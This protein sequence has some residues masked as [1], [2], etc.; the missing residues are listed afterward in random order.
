MNNPKIIFILSNIYEIANG[1][2]TKYITFIEYLLKNNYNVL[3]FTTFKNI[4]NYQNCQKDNNLKIIKTKGLIIPFYNTIKIPI[5]KE[6]KLK[7]HITEGNEIVI[8]NGEFIWLYETLY[9]IKKKYLNI[10]LYPNMH[11]DYIYY[12]N[13]VYSKF[14]FYNF[15]FDYTSLLSYLDNYLEKKIFNGIIVTGE[16]LK[17]K[18][19]LLTNS[20]FNANEINLDTFN[21]IKKDD[22]DG[23]FYNIIYCGRISK[24]KNIE[25][26]IDCCQ[27][28][29]DKYNYYLN[30]IGDGPYLDTLKTIIELEYSKI[31]SKIIFHGNKDQKSINSLYQSMENRIFLFTS[32]SETFG[33]T[34]MEAG[35]T[36]IPIFI[37]KCDITDILYINKKNAMIFDNKNDFF[38]LFVYFSEMDKFE[39]DLFISNSIDN[40]KKYDQ[41][42]IFKDWIQFL[43]E[44]KV[45]KKHSVV[46]FYDMFTF[47]GITKFINCSGSIIA[48]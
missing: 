34:P 33:K 44:G 22:Y 6:S 28:L 41:N 38:E 48:D 5:I 31:K 20:V 46:N 35:A 4:E 7:E 15:K 8:F 1:V 37:K 47:H 11:T 21:N 29:N 45:L 10:K 42:I 2:S 25:E 32:I 40:I 12:G 24:E 18:Y 30:I 27:M 14:K 43:I 23:N 16:K 19:S 3:L 17:D 39:K 13:E 26:I 36:G 9:K